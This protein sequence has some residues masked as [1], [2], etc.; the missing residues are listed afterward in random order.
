[1]HALRISFW[2][3]ADRG[4][5]PVWATLD[6]QIRAADYDVT[7]GDP[8]W[9]PRHKA[10]HTD[11]I[12]Q[13]V[14]SSGLPEAISSVGQVG[15]HSVSR[16]DAMSFRRSMGSAWA[17]RSAVERICVKGLGGRRYLLS[18]AVRGCMKDALL[19]RGQDLAA[20]ARLHDA[21]LPIIPC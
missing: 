13:A 12:D 11:R 3:T 17:K 14:E 5:P 20:L 16:V 4:G 6:G 7:S 15:G 18:W 1:M 10:L 8:L 9:F 19:E 2:Y 21:C